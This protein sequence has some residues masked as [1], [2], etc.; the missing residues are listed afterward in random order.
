LSDPAARPTSEAASGGDTSLLRSS[1]IVALGTALS[2][3][4]GFARLA[5]T[6]YAIGFGA[7]ND[8][9]T[10]ANTTPN[11]VYELLLGGVLSATLVPVFVHHTEE[12]DDEGTSAVISIA[13]A[14]LVAVTVIGF[15]AA[16]AIVRIYTV[17][18]EA[19]VADEQR[20]VATHF[21]RLF[22]PQMVF[23]GLTALGTAVLNARRSF[24]VPA[25]VPALNNLLVTGVLIAL[26]HVAGHDPTL[27]DMRDDTG[28]LLLLGLGT[29]AGVVVMTLAL[30]PAFRRS[31]FR[32]R[33]NFDVRNPA[34]REVGR[35]SSWTL[36][37]VLTNQLVLLVIFVLANRQVGGVSTYTAAYVFFL[38]P[39]ALIAVSIMTTF[40]P[41]LASAA[42]AGDRAAYRDRFSAGIRLMTLV[43]LPAATGYVILARPILRA[44]LQRGALD[45]AA[46]N[47]AADDLVMFSLGLLGY[48]MYLFTLRGFYADRDTKTPFLL[49]LLQNA[50]NIALA[51][52]LEPSLGVPGLALAFGLSYTVAAVVAIWALRRRMGALDVWRIL[53]SLTRISI[54]SLVM[55]GAVLLVLRVVPDVDI[56][57]TVVG[58]GVG[59]VVYVV[60]VLVL[61][62]EEVATL[63]TRFLHR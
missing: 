21:L 8:T 55:A 46:A 51:F 3:S 35:M 2:R 42:R 12:D 26:P 13:T 28:L 10:L 39:H 48:S 19:G 60:A 37:Y 58:M 34:V 20:E 49:G 30:L 24:A 1:G 57:K 41:E 5:A 25:F 62:V 33:P 32:F 61:R 56:I 50:L 11:I 22:M 31:G 6:A 52:A 17:T 43:I 59:A 40:V 18:A 63:R 7:L 23:Y 45:A 38:L 44:L 53:R 36:G 15:L 47:L 9:Y 16:P 54:A 27:A 29:T 4:T 14:A